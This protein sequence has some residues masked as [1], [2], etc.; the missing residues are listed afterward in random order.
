V[1]ALDGPTERILFPPY[2]IP[3]F[4]YNLGRHVYVNDPY[5][6]R[7]LWSEGKLSVDPFIDSVSAAYF[8][9]VV[10]PPDEDLGRP[11]YGF[12][13]V[14][15]DRFYAALRREYRRARV[16]AFQYHVRRESAPRP[17]VAAQDRAETAAPAVR[18]PS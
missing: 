4:A 15:M 13:R 9:V 2:M 18:P 5:L 12:V 10:V 6:Y 7:L 16:G 17:T 8:D 11:K 14:G 1:A 3:N